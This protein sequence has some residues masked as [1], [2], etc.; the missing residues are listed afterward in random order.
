MKKCK[1]ILAYAKVQYEEINSDEVKTLF[2]GTFQPLFIQDNTKLLS[3]VYKEETVLDTVDSIISD[4]TINNTNNVILYA[5]DSNKTNDL[6]IEKIKSLNDY[7]SLYLLP[8][9]SSDLTDVLSFIEEYVNKFGSL[10]ETLYQKSNYIKL[11]YLINFIYGALTNKND[12]LSS[13]SGMLSFSQIYSRALT[14]KIKSS[15]ILDDY[16][17]GDI[18]QEEAIKLINKYKKILNAGIKQ[19][20]Y[21]EEMNMSDDDYS[22]IQDDIES[23]LSSISFMEMELNDNSLNNDFF[24][25]NVDHVNSKLLDPFEEETIHVS[26]KIDDP[27]GDEENEE[28]SLD[29]VSFSAISPR[30]MEKGDYQI[31]QVVMY[32]DDSRDV[33]DKMIKEASFD[34]PVKETIGA[35]L[36]IEEGTIVKVVLSSPDIEIDDNEVALKWNGKYQN[37]E[38]D[39]YIPEEYQKKKILFEAKVYFNDVPATRLKFLADI[40]KDETELNVSRNDIKKAFI[41]YASKDRDLVTYIIQGLRKARPDLDLFFDVETLRSGDKWEECLGKAIDDSDI[42]FL[43]WS[44]NA[45]DSKWVEYEWNY[46]LNKKGIE[47]IEP[48]PLDDPRS[49]PPPSKLSSMHFNDTLIYVR[50]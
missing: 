20:E 21:Q 30:K 28:C 35:R 50:K 40:S 14:I 24:E 3:A 48:I 27:F 7:G 17:E 25:D 29:T 36:E 43:C 16:Y 2:N 11:T 37:F 34:A 23:I 12:N 1:I 46:A 6:M 13:E 39:I 26:H 32:E 8:I 49:C 4:V 47:A 44:K 41:S 22:F 10:F 15:S 5:F 31:I 45:S 19:Y 9:G 18:D 38:F 33:V 42:L